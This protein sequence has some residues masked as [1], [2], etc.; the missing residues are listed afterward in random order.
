MIGTST[1]MASHRNQI[2]RS[3]VTPWIKIT[4]GPE[5]ACW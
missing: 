4:S 1:P 3:P 2:D 5:P